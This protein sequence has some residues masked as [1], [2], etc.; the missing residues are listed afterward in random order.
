MP[1]LAP[2]ALAAILSLAGALPAAAQQ[3]GGAGPMN[4]IAAKR[5][6]P[7]VGNRRVV[8][9]A[10]SVELPADIGR[11]AHTHYHIV[12]EPQAGATPTPPTPKVGPPYPG[13]L[14]ETPGSL[15]CIYKLVPTTPGCNPN[16]ATIV[17]TGGSR[18]IALV[19]A[20][21]LPTAASDLQTFSTQ[22]GLPAATFRTVYATGT[23]PTYDAG[24]SVEEALDIEMAHA[25]APSASI[26]LVEAASNSLDD[27]GTAIDAAYNLV[28]QAGGGEVSM[29]FGS[30]EASGE[31]AFEAHFA[32]QGNVTFYAST[33]DSAGTEYPSTSPNVVAV[34]GTA[35]SREAITTVGNYGDFLQETAWASAG[36]GF[37]TVFPR[38][39]FQHALAKTFFYASTRA[40]PDVAAVAS[41]L[42]PVWIYCTA[43]GW[44]PISGTSVA[45]PLTAGMANKWGAFHASSQAALQSIYANGTSKAFF[46]PTLGVCGPDAGYFSGRGYD[47]CTGL[48]TPR[49]AKAF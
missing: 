9:P 32:K 27:L 13:F 15:A 40:V 30:S 46:N 7:G 3:L 20:Y 44:M 43:C 22:F 48:G 39:A 45:A 42:T 19:D 23:Q 37:S 49:S 47:L 33:G 36:S 28:Q 16:S 1:S 8:V 26:V 6:G 38:P 4:V 10:S 12:V 17:A 14:V 41:D 24:W 2:L 31:A 11:R 21:D 18:M 34:G 25:M 5:S 35:T 29:S